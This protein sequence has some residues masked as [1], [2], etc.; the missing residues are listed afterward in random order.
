M[1]KENI[2]FELN[3]GK[4]RVQ[5]LADGLPN[6]YEAY[7]DNA[8]L[9]EE[10]DLDNPDGTPC[11]LSVAGQG[12]WPFLTLA[13][14]YS[15][16]GGGFRPGCLL[17][18]ETDLLFLGA[19]ERL[20]C[21]NLNSVQHVWED[22]ADIGFW[23][24]S[25]YGD[26]VLMAAELELAAWTVEGKKLWTTEVEPP[27]DYQVEKGRVMLEVMGHSRVFDLDKGPGR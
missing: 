10:F 8:D 22:R 6:L 25:R 23:H 2:S 21:Y 4:Y 26:Y 9:A 18:P 24:W 15:P 27:W 20:W 19:G 12:G 16:S 5:C 11:F 1:E 7:R 13:L 14:K 3:T 17:I